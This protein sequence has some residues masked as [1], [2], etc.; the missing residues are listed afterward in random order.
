MIS[1]QFM[2]DSESRL[3][4]AIQKMLEVRKGGATVDQSSEVMG[5]SQ[6]SG[7]DLD[8]DGMTMDTQGDDLDMTGITME[9]KSRTSSHQQ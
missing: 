9:D 6:D 4:E 1:A 8:M 5:E 2:L 3:R 7:D